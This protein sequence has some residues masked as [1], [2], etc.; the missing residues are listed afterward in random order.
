VAIGWHDEPPTSPHFRAR[1][2]KRNS[3]SALLFDGAGQLLVVEPTYEPGWTLPGG[4]VD[5]GESPRQACEREVLEEVGLRRR[6]GRLL[7]VEWKPG[8]DTRGEAMLWVFD[9][10]V[11]SDDEVAAITLPAEELSAHELVPPDQ[12]VSLIGTHSGAKAR[13]VRAAL[14]ARAAGTV[15]W[16]DDGAT[17]AG[18]PGPGHDR[19]GDGA[20]SPT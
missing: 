4:A 1:D 16:L 7:A 5:A 17:A 2:R 3:A 11:L 9:G 18:G 10:G 6:A 13:R 15:A 12:A 20:G 8:D 19:P 14:D